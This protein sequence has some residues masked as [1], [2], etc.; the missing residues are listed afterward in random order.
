MTLGSTVIR[1]EWPQDGAVV[2]PIFMLA[3]ASRLEDS[4]ELAD[5]FLSRDAGEILSHRGR[6][7]VLDPRV[8]N[9]LPEGAG[10]LW[11]GWDRIGAMDV[12]EEIPR[13]NARFEKAAGV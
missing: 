8:D 13:L 10:F 1:V 12:G 2:S 3:R 9:R 11:L 7:P 4:R 5:L 6:F